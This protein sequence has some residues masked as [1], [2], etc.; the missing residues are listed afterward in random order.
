V[1]CAL[2]YV[3]PPALDG[4]SAR[5]L[6]K[7]LL[8]KLPKRFRTS[9]SCGV[10]GASGTARRGGVQGPLTAAS[11]AGPG[12]P[13]GPGWVELQLVVSPGPGGSQVPLRRTSCGG[14]RAQERD[15][16][17]SE[18]Q[19]GSSWLAGWLAAGSRVI[20]RC[21][22]CCSKSGIHWVDLRPQLLRFES[23]QGCEQTCSQQPKTAR[24]PESGRATRGQ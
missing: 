16:E 19:R 18:G 6:H 2:A 12:E 14:G 11:P 8:T 13:S 5:P 22:C 3:A 23:I 10:S 9:W 24:N 4:H 7:W 21:W 20:V 17:G 1:L 15:E